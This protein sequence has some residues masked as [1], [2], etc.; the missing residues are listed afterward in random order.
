VVFTI[1]EIYVKQSGNP[2]GSTLS[3]NYLLKCYEETLHKILV[4]CKEENV[5]VSIDEQL[6]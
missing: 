2:Y 1:S 3:K 5:W 6:I 4:F